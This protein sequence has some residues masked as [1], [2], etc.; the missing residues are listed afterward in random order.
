MKLS[1]KT[2]DL[3]SE[4]DRFSG[5]KIKN[6]DDLSFLIEITESSQKQKLFG[7]IQFTA[8]YL[9]GLTKILESNVNLSTN[10]NTG[11]GEPQPDIG[12]SREK[13]LQEYKANMLKL[14]AYLKDLLTEADG[15]VK[16]MLEEKYLA[17]S[18]ESMKNMTTLIYDLSWL[19]K[20]NNSKRRA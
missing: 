20:F 2:S 15:N 11:N 14:I 12:E 5:S 9:N 3:I 19:K 18:K 16:G 6:A 7:D 10:K 4:L 13:I 17:L 8:K 1:Q